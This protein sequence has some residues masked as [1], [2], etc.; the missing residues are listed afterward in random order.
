MSDFFIF[1]LAAAVLQN[2]VLMTGFG[3][4]VLIR[5]T[6][7][8]TNIIPFFLLLCLFATLTMLIFYPVD[9]LIGTDVLSKWV[10]PL[11][12]MLITSLLYI[13]TVL[14]LQRQ[15]RLYS[16]IGRLLPATAFNN[17]V[18]GIALIANHQFALTLLGA[19]G[20]SLGACV[21]FFILSWLTAEGMERLD[22]PDVPGAFRGLPSILIYLGIL[23]M[24]LMGFSGS[25]SMI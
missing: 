24:S 1:F 13:I 23:A 6:R 9:M 4:S 11:L 17:L 15:K 8:R 7:K 16:R 10:R 22:N 14:I 18:I 2:V 5:I 3:S 19:L 21:G 20:L 12:I 25:I